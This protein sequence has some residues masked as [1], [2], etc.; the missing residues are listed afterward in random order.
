MFE[1]VVMYLV[2]A[3]YGME[4]GHITWSNMRADCEKMVKEIYEKEGA[5]K[6]LA[7]QRREAQAQ[8]KAEEYVLMASL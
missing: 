8:A 3:K 5:E 1:K 7:Q 4:N 6:L 2:T